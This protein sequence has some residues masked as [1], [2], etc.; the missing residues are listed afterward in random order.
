MTSEKYPELP[1]FIEEWANEDESTWPKPPECLSDDTD[2]FTFKR[3]VKR[4]TN[5]E[6]TNEIVDMDGDIKQ[7][8]KELNHSLLANYLAIV[9]KQIETPYEKDVIEAYVKF[10]QTLIENIHRLLNAYRPNQAKKYY[11]SLFEKQVEQKEKLYR[12]LK[13]LIDESN[14]KYKDV[15][16]K[17]KPMEEC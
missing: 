12:E 10:F 1:P 9:N 13:A 7:Q 4:E 6:P 5:T 8:L 2:Y 11:V 14:A 15:P 17:P 16:I 3:I